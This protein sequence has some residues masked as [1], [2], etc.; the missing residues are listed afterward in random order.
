MTFFY[1]PSGV[2]EEAA[3]LGDTLADAVGPVDSGW[4]DPTTGPVVLL[5]FASAK[6]VLMKTK[7]SLQRNKISN[8]VVFDITFPGMIVDGKYIKALNVITS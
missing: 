7:M 5:A 2:R 4:A 1:L 3:E 8:F 6:S